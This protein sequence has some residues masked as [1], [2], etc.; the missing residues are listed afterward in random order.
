[1]KS[2]G[3]VAIFGLVIASVGVWMV[4]G[5]GWGLIVFGGGFYIDALIEQ[6]ERD[7]RDK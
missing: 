1:M 3:Y 2:S 4:A 5:L 6:K 7:G